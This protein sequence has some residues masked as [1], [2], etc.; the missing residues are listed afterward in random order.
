MLASEDQEGNEYRKDEKAPCDVHGVCFKFFFDA[1]LAAEHA[2]GS[3]ADYSGQTFVF[4]RL[5]EHENDKRNTDQYI[6][7]YQKDR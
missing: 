1:F 2:L 4:G 7:D 3:T 5:Y 6:K